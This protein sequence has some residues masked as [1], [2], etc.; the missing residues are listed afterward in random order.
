MN[1]RT[2]V[3]SQLAAIAGL[4]WRMFTNGLRTRRGKMELVSRIIVALAFAFGG[5]GGFAAA[6]GFAW[7]FVNNGKPEYLAIL[8][9]PIF[10]FWQVFPVMRPPSPIIQTLRNCCASRSP[11]NHIS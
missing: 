3:L 10:F 2:K 7:S 9:W 1:A 11:T 4:R 8:L 6:A 5:L